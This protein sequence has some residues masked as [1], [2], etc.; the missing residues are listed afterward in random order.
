[1]SLAFVFPG[2][3]SQAVGMMTALAADHPEV[4]AVFEEASEAL[5]YD[6]WKIVEQGPEEQ[7]N[8]TQITQPAMLSAGVAVWRVWQASNGRTPLLMAGHSLGEYTALVCAEALGFADAI[9]LVA[10]RGR[11]MQEAVPAGQGAMAAVL[12]LDDEAVRKVC[13]EAAGDEVLEAVNYNSPGQVVIAGHAAAVARGVEQARAAGAKRALVLPVSGPFHSQLMHPAAVRL[14]ERLRDVA[15]EA[16][17][18]PVLHNVHVETE[19]RADGIRHA[20]VRQIESPVRW[21]ETIQKMVA[22]GVDRIVECGPGRV[23]AGLNKRIDKR[24][25]TLAVYDPTTLSDA[26]AKC[27]GA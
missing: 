14:M 5:S 7:L 16:P 10:D 6:L 15:F 8:Q 26:L 17:H 25:E 23:L 2:Q 11:F 20:L 3:G 21:V 22:A 9:R 18:V 1:M 4:K 19:T 12:G 27:A 13:A 24:A